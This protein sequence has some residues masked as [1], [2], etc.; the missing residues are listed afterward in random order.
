ME[1]VRSSVR[2]LIGYRHPLYKLAA[3]ALD[4][5]A[6]VKKE[7][8]KAWLMLRKLRYQKEGSCGQSSE[9]SL[10]LRSL[11]HPISVRPGTSD[12]ETL[13]NNILR[14][15]YGVFDFVESPSWMIDAGSYIGD[16]SAYFLSRFPSLQVISL[17][18]APSSYELASKNLKPYGE[19]S[20]LQNIGLSFEEAVVK[21]SGSNTGAAIGDSDSA[22]DVTCKTIPSLLEEYNIGKLDIL[23]LDIEGAEKS[24]FLSE[25]ESWLSLVDLIII[26][27]HGPDIE[28][29]VSEVLLRNNFSMKRFRSVWFCKRN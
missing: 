23:K 28:E 5:F 27:I 6:T 24:I 18:P 19:R 2:D 22:I 13:M 12:V 25:P 29:I 21:F 4:C 26:E 20:H 1:F 14:E 7:G 8:L 15:E 9:V 17:E 11:Q 16:T 3:A 10:N